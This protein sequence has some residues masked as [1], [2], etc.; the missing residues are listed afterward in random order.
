VVRGSSDST[1]SI[2]TAFLL[3]ATLIVSG[4]LAARLLGAE[5]RGIL[6]LLVLYPAVLGVVGTF[7]IPA[8]TTFHIAK[9]PNSASSVIAALA[10]PLVVVTAALVLVHAAIVL[11]LRQHDSGEIR[12]AAL[13]TLIGVPGVVLQ[14]FGMAIVQG[15]QKFVLYNILRT[16]QLVAY[17]AALVALAVLNQDDLAL[18]SG[19]WAA[20]MVLGAAVVLPL[21][22][23]LA[24]SR[25][26]PAPV[27]RRDMLRFGARSMLGTANFVEVVRLD[28]LAVSLVAGP[29][30]LGLYVVGASVSNLPRFIATSIGMVAFPRVASDEAQGGKTAVRYFCLAAL[31]CGLIVLGLEAVLGVIVPLFFGEDFHA[32]V[33]VG[34]VLL[35]SAFLYSLRR[36]AGDCARG[37]GM[38]ELPSIAE[39]V[40]MA[41]LL[42]A[43]LVFSEQSELLGVA[44]ALAVSSAVGLLTLVALMVRAYS[45]QK[46]DSFALPLEAPSR[47]ERSMMKGLS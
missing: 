35:I 14:S 42:P 39:I 26:A 7:G 25:S 12:T 38:P 31:I 34:R 40:S 29:T 46:T 30:V 2:A 21:A 19:A 8:S 44:W 6:A 32:S 22:L 23:H 9:A 15:L 11:I 18:I 36:V 37:L 28:Q 24:A 47:G 1:I 5:S 4:V 13:A 27:G 45:S 10:G 43:I 41:A 20:S 17:G 33:N 3:Q 16:L